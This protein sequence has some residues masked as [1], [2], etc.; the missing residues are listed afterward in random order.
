MQPAEKLSIT[1][2]AEMARLIR[3]KVESGAYASASEVIREAVRGWL[4]RERQFALLEAAVERGMVDAD[5]G[6][7]LSTEDLRRTLLAGLGAARDKLPT[8]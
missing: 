2:P 6:R 1:L 4:E 8:P 3:A 7:S 5:A